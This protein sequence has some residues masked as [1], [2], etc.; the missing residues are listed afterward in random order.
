MNRISF[1]ERCSLPKAHSV[2]TFPGE[3]HKLEF[4]LDEDN[5]KFTKNSN[6]FF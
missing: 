3:Y 1:R 6:V 4:G 2:V 5:V